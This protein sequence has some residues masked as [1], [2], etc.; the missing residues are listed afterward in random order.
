MIDIEQENKKSKDWLKSMLGNFLMLQIS[1][2]FFAIIFVSKYE[3]IV[4]GVL[5]FI[6]VYMY[7]KLLVRLEPKLEVKKLIADWHK[8]MLI[9]MVCLFLIMLCM[10][11]I[12]ILISGNMSIYS[13]DLETFVYV[14]SFAPRLFDPF[15]FIYCFLIGEIAF[16]ISLKM[17]LEQN[18]AEVD[19]E[20]TSMHKEKIEK[21][22]SLFSTVAIL[23]MLICIIFIVFKM[24]SYYNDAH[25]HEHTLQSISKIQMICVCKK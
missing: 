14:W 18:S 19:N 23:L 24:K 11:G 20:K 10:Q 17:G 8:K 21:R 6:M 15:I 7:T 3:A 25:L 22:F 4:C 12:Y 13:F 2:L 9:A 5:E 16:Y 1:I